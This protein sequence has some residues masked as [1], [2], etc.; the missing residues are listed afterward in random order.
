MEI[1]MRYVLVI[2]TALCAFTASANAAG[3]NGR[4]CLSEYLAGEAVNC[5]FQSL[6]QCNKS[7]TANSDTCTQNPRSTTGSG[8]YEKK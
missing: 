3:S 4:W 5:S 7:K 6:A 8:M 2:A 1:S